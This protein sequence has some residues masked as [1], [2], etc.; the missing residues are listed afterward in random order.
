MSVFTFAI[1][2]QFTLIHGP[3]IPDSHAILLFTAS[4]FTFTTRYIHN[5]E[6]F[7][8]WFS[9]F[10]PSGAIS[11]LFSSSILDTYRPGEITFQCPIFL[12][13][14]TVHGVL[15]ARI[16][17][18]FAIPFSSG[19]HSVRPL[20]HDLS[21]LGWPH[22]TWLSFIELDKAVVLVW[23][24]WLVFCEYGFSVSAL[25]C[26]LGTPT[27]LLGFLLLWTWGVSSRLLQQSAATAPYI[28]RGVSPF[29]R[30]SW[31]WTWGSSSWW[32]LCS[33]HSWNP[34]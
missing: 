33:R 1:S 27:V 2:C 16:L 5:W 17:K 21:H 29:G 19:P 22:T 13:F 20:H 32:L 14:P 25:W 30:H 23:L 31:P 26:P 28:E 7:P 6:L 8:L 24:D 18:R 15:K 4:D 3:S 9:L 12:P 10:I 34:W 11:L